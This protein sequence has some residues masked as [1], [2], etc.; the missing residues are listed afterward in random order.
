MLSKRIIACLDVRGGKLAK[1]VRF[2]DTKDIGDPVEQAR[3]YYLQGLDELVFYDITASNEKRDIM[4]DVV[5]RVAAQVFIP[6]SVGGGLRTVEDCSRVLLA[7]AEKVNVNSAA[8]GNPRLIAEA[9]CAFGAQAVVLSMDVRQTDA[10][11][12]VPS[13]YEIIING[14]RTPTGLDA[15]QWACRG[16]ELGAG[17]LVV[18]SIDADGT[19]QGY[20]IRLTRMIAESVGI[21]V[22]AS[23]GGGKPEHLYDVLT[24]GKADAALVASMLH[25]GEYTVGGIKDYLVGRGIKVRMPKDESWTDRS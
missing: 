9:A 8:V 24:E 17:E 6:F 4:I 15:V 5:G 7:G 3:K 1:S 25:Y 2:V 13:G 18:N 14:G 10:S 11:P 22:I 19:R 12:Q 23:G 21:P 16:E 20:E